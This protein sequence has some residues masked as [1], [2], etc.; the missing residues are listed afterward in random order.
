MGLVITK[1]IGES[2]S[3]EGPC[4][5]EVVGVRGDRVR[6]NIEANPRTRIYRN[7]KE[8]SMGSNPDVQP[9]DGSMPPPDNTTKLPGQ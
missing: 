8:W 6:V 9:L 7:G 2:F 4:L 3:C 1:R 5:V